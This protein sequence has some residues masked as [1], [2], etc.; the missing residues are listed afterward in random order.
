MILDKTTKYVWLK[1]CLGRH[2]SCY[3]KMILLY[4]LDACKHVCENV[5]ELIYSNQLFQF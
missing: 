3:L 4:T 5:K 2:C 1:F